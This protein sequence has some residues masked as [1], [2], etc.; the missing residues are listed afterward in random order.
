MKLTMK[1]LFR[2]LPHGGE[3]T[4]LAALL[5]GL[6]AHG[7]PLSVTNVLTAVISV[8]DNG[9]TLNSA[10]WTDG[11]VAHA[12]ADYLID[13]T[14]G[15][16]LPETNSVFNGNSL[17][18]GTDT[19]AVSFYQKPGGLTFAHDGLFLK[20][21]TWGHWD[22]KNR[23]IG[24]NVTVL[25][26]KTAAARFSCSDGKKGAGLT[27]TGPWAGADG[28]SIEVSSAAPRD[29][30]FSL[31]GDLSG[32]LG[33][34]RV[35]KGAVLRLGETTFP[36][37]L[38]MDDASGAGVL[39]TADEATRVTLGSLTL[40]AGTTL[41]PPARLASATATATSGSFRVTGALAVTGPVAVTRPS[42]LAGGA[43]I[44]AASETQRFPLLTK[45]A[46]ASG[47]LTADDFALTNATDGTVVDELLSL[48]V[49]ED[50]GTGD[51][52]LDLVRKPVVLNQKVMETNDLDPFATGSF[53]S[54]GAAPH[55]GVVYCSN[56]K[57][58]RTLAGAEEDTFA[59][60]ALVLDT[61][62]VLQSKVVNIPALYCKS[63]ESSSGKYSS[64]S[65][66][67][68]HAN[69]DKTTNTFAVGGTK[70]V[71]GRRF[72]LMDTLANTIVNFSGIGSLVRI[73]ASVVGPGQLSVTVTDSSL[74]DYLELAGDNAKWT[75]RLTA[76]AYTGTKR[77]EAS[78]ANTCEI[79]F[80]K[81]VHLGGPLASASAEAVVLQNK[82]V[83]R[84]LETMTW[85]EP[86]RGLT[87]GDKGGGIRT[88]A[89]VVFTVMNPIALKG[90][91]GK[92][93][94]GTL[95]L[96]GAVS[97]NGSSV[98]DVQEGGVRTCAKEAVD[99]LTLAFG[100]RGAIEAD[101]TATGDAATYGLYN[102]KADTPFDLTATGG[103]VPVRIALP[104]DYS[105][106]DPRHVTATICTV[107]AAAA[108]NLGTEA[109]SVARVRRCRT[110]VTAATNDDGTVTYTAH[111]DASG[112]AVIIR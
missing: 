31:L 54:D 96:G 80:R 52:T 107:S 44:S 99:G 41:E 89:G 81:P 76:I 79:L 66:Q 110:Y 68:W 112:M 7:S 106:T 61:Q 71:K 53:W 64:P 111:V 24:G 69:G 67:N 37:A 26:S 94:D 55:A 85:D 58:I 18:L 50:E 30:T 46:A 103:R 33:A 10:N 90:S 22:T 5:V 92:L 101:V 59:G 40:K 108:A 77:T 86:T 21:V 109:F 16:R 47:A 49:G 8:T 11:K 48:A 63:Y 4:L 2:N 87:V 60:D 39:T 43:A 17:Q 57:L 34:I 98:I 105:A 28:T 1:S 82:A 12:D 13:L 73:D 74:G 91:L 83:L 51:T 93:G 84:P 32:Y 78:Y 27:F 9:G 97:A 3:T 20:N 75:G 45:A 35:Y 23:T 70:V 36:G 19:K 14:N 29:Y 65:I 72:A 88:G 38:T 104:A 15:I 6:S 56:N 25:A 100:A 102:V 62:L 42:S 95:V